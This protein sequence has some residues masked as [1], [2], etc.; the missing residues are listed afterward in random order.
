MALIYLSRKKSKGNV[1]IGGW[2]QLFIGYLFGYPGILRIRVKD[3][4]RFVI[5]LH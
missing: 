3:G 2:V 1:G 4:N 5:L